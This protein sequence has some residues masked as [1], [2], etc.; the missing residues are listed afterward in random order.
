[1]LLWNYAVHMGPD[2]PIKATVSVNNWA[3]PPTIMQNYI[4]SMFLSVDHMGC[5]AYQK[6][7]N[8]TVWIYDCISN[9]YFISL[10]KK[11]TFPATSGVYR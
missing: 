4:D 5:S 8:R 1:M 11:E 2:S 6:K 9:R 10:D 3:L 7:K